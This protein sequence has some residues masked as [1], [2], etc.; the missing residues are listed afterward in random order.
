MSL[1][2]C[3]RG[4]IAVLVLEVVLTLAFVSSTR[5]E[6]I[7][8]QDIA[9]GAA[10]VGA[11]AQERITTT[12]GSAL[13][14]FHEAWSRDE[15][16]SAEQEDAVIAPAQR[17]SDRVRRKALAFLQIFT[18]RLAIAREFI[19]PALAC[20]VAAAIDGLAIRRRRAFTFATTSTVVY[21]AA[22]YGLLLAV[23]IPLL[24]FAAPVALSMW[25]FPMAGLGMVLATWA[26]F[27][28]FPGAAP[29]IGLR[30]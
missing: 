30:T 8:S 14:W 20:M 1:G 2:G 19:G 11:G 16:P 3:L 22:T 12:T 7:A 26:F 29:I 13:A 4:A 6:A 24:Y 15:H 9:S 23:M 17:G 10:M 5:L 25:A 21:N 28:Y 27:A 18:I